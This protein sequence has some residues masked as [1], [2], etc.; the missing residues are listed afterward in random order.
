MSASSARWSASGSGRRSS[1]WSRSQWSI[2]FMFRRSRFGV[3]VM[4]TGGNLL[5]AAE[6]G[7]PIR[8]VKV[9]CFVLCSFLSGHRRHRRRRQ[10]R[11][12]GPGQRRRELHPLRRGR[13]CHRRNGPH[14]G[15]GT[16]IGAFIGAILIGVLEAGLTGHRR[17]HERLLRLHR[18]HNDPRHDPERL[19]RPSRRPH[20]NELTDGETMSDN[21]GPDLHDDSPDQ[22]RSRAR[23]PGRDEGLRTALG[24]ARHRPDAAPRARFSAWSATTEPARA[25]SSRS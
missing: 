22:L 19:A 18:R 15:R 4:A 13:L 23:G 3:R 25:P 11:E 24:A 14:G 5:G 12:H 16:V 6:A 2:H 10:V 17:Q 8:R 9:W 20:E 7:V 21:V 1:G